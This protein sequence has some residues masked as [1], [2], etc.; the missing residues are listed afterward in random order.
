MK[1]SEQFYDWV[2]NN[3]TDDKR[4]KSL[5]HIR[6]ACDMIERRREPKGI[7]VARVG[8]ICESEFKND[9]T[10]KGPKAQSIR[11]SSDILKKY[12]DLRAAEQKLPEKATDRKL[13]DDRV[14]AES[15]YQIALATIAQQRGEIERLRKEIH[16]YTPRSLE[17][18]VEDARVGGPKV[19]IPAAPQIAPE[20]IEAIKILLDP[21]QQARFELEIDKS[22]YLIHTVSR[23]TLFTPKQ[24]EALRA[25][26]GEIHLSIALKSEET[27]AAIEQD[28]TA[29]TA[30]MVI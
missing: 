7:Y 24:V 20:A 18:L 3:T 28:S 5:E 10:V 15:Q 26:T 13:S 4:K 12:V 2:M 19:E 30:S 16:N 6:I 29:S 8:E 25:L 27:A 17:E 14:Q 9:E 23:D 11:N 22:G 21:G 1:A